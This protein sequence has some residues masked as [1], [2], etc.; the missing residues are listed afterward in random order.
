M[1]R[2]NVVKNGVVTNQW[3]SDKGD[4]TY[5]ESGFG[6]Q[7]RWVTAEKED[8][9]NATQT[10]QVTDEFTGEVRTEYFLPKEY[11][12]I[13]E[14]ITAEISA[15]E[16]NKKDQADEA[17]GK[18]F[19]RWIKGLNQSAGITEAQVIALRSDNRI[20]IANDLCNGGDIPSLKYHIQNTDWTGLF[21]ETVKLAAISKINAYLGV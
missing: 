20:K 2:Y 1:M 11:E 15:T 8:V 17:F 12:V 5:Y 3:T 19:I 14:D 21:P 9:T 6:K 16:K 4:A 10:R 13:E 7:D 18:D